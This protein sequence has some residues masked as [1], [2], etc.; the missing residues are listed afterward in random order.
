MASLQ[1]VTQHRTQ[2]YF[3]KDLFRAIKKA[4]RKE[5]VSMAEIIRRAVIREIGIKKRVKEK[6]REKKRIWRKFFAHAGIGSGPK[7]LSYNHD[8]YFEHQ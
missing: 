3:P 8:K 5:D 7:D 1:S 2:V 4:S 6:T